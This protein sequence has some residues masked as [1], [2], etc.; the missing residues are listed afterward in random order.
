[1]NGATD[2]G[3]E[4]VMTQERTADWDEVGR[5]F[6]EL[7]RRLQSAWEEGRAGHAGAGE[8]E[9]GSGSGSG[10]KVTAAV[11]ELKASITHTVQAP[12]VRQAVGYATN[13]LAETL[14]LSLRQL[15]DWVDRKA[16]EG[17]PGAAASAPAADPDAPPAYPPGPT[18][19]P[20]TPDD[21][22]PPGTPTL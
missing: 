22:P 19:G 12:Q 11:D 13:G 3:T 9:G 14:A 18:A 6:G 4:V 7:G 21:G 17:D 15:A 5:R 10:T 8:G 1:M 16:P 2:S 20:G